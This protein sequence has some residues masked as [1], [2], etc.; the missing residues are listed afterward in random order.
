MRRATGYVTDVNWRWKLAICAVVFWLGISHSIL[1]QQTISDDS[2]K[3]QRQRLAMVMSNLMDSIDH[4]L[5]I[6]HRTPSSGNPSDAGVRKHARELMEFRSQLNDTIR[7]S[8]SK[9]DWD[10]DTLKQKAEM[11]SKIR[12][13]YHRIRGD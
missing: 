10:V 3:A 7:D 9:A 2:L 11:V 12:D 5:Q 1:G 4:Q 6:I 8:H 13:R